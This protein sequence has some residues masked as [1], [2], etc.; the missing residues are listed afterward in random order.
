[1]EA[2]IILALVGAALA[3]DILAPRFGA[4]SRDPLADDYRRPIVP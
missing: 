3:L 2:L 1:M 4:D